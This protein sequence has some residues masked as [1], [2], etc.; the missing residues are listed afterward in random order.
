M[1]AEL[2][3]QVTDYA[4]AQK[5]N[6]IAD[7]DGLNTAVKGWIAENGLSERQGKTVHFR[8]D[9]V[10]AQRGVLRDAAEELG[11][12]ERPPM[13]VVNNDNRK[14]VLRWGDGTPA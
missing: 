9:A 8:G 7:L 11:Q 3:R 13:L 1:L 2:D 6:R 5:V 12:I 4:I 14:Y 10:N